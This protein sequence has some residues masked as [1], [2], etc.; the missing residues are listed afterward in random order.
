MQHKKLLHQ[1]QLEKESKYSTDNDS[2]TVKKIFKKKEKELYD[3]IKI[4]E[5]ERETL[6][7]QSTSLKEKVKFL[8]SKLQGS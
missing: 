5:L 7:S 1:L 3:Q 4:L 2:S 8:E 6:F